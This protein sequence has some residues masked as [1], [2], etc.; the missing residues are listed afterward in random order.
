MS[1]LIVITAIISED[2]NFNLSHDKLM[3]EQA[4]DYYKYANDPGGSG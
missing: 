4:K 2:V 1:L 3:G